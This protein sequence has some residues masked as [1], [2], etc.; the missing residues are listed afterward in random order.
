MGQVSNSTEDASS[1]FLDNTAGQHLAA[2]EA[3]GLEQRHNQ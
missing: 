1:G 2:F 3:L